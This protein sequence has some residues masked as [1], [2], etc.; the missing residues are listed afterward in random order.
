M[1]D[2]YFPPE[3]EVIELEKYLKNEDLETHES[4]SQGLVDLRKLFTE[5]EERRRDIRRKATG[6]LAVCGLL[7]ALLQFAYEELV[8]GPALIL[9]A[10]LLIVSILLSL[11]NIV[12]I[13]YRQ[14]PSPG[15]TLSYLDEPRSEYEASMYRKY[16]LA[17]WHNERVNDS[18]YEV[19]GWSYYPLVVVVLAL[20]IVMVVPPSVEVLG[21]VS[22]SGAAVPVG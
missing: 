6:I 16:F 14:P 15:A 18:R 10:S 22:A 17:V 1:S 7:L 11:A 3:E 20:A 21:T 12:P 9:L 13:E 2:L 5:E 19:L 4:L 8:G